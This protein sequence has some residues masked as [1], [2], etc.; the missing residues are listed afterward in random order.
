MS[1]IKTPKLRGL[2]SDGYLKSGLKLIGAKTG[3]T[4]NSGRSLIYEMLPKDASCYFEPFLGSGSVLVGKPAHD[5]EIVSDINP[6]VINFFQQ[7]QN[8]PQDLWEH[9]ET[10]TDYMAREYD[11]NQPYYKFFHYLR[12]SQKLPIG[13]EGAVWYYLINKYCMN[14]IVRFNET[15]KCNSSWCKT[16]RGRGIFDREW[17]EAVY[18]RIQ[19]VRFSHNLYQELVKKANLIG[20]SAV[21]V[22]DPPYQGVFTSYDKVKFTDEDHMVL[23]GHL[24]MADFRW[25]LTINDTKFVRRLYGGFNFREVNINYCCSNTSEGRG[26]KPELFITNY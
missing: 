17:Y 9:I 11:S 14:G 4:K 8:N 10:M 13:V 24:R 12:D 22:L 26:E 19:K 5:L 18:D 16:Y 3:F 25:L 20:E 21:M 2:A 23:A 1:K 7:M 15:G 6:Y